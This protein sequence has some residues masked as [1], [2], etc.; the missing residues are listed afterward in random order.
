MSLARI[1]GRIS[2]L[3]PKQKIVAL[4]QLNA[5]IAT[6]RWT[7][8]KTM[9]TMPHEY[10]VRKHW[11][12]QTGLSFDDAVAIVRT[13]GYAA[14]WGRR[15]FT[16]L[17]VNGWKYWTMG[18]PIAETTI[19]N[20]A[21]VEPEAALYDAIAG[22]YDSLFD[23]AQSQT[24][25]ASVIK[26]AEPQGRVLDIGCGTGALLAHFPATFDKT[27]YTGIDISAGMVHIAQQ[28]Y[29]TL[30]S[31][32]HVVPFHDWWDRGYDTVLALFG[33]ASYLQPEDIERIPYLLTPTGRAILMFYDA[34]YRPQTHQH[35]HATHGIAAPQYVSSTTGQL[36][37]DKY[38]VVVMTHKSLPAL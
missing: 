25:N 17:H 9:P 13:Y 28:Q 18:S 35:A 5:A 32:F 10:A 11:N 22:Q 29:Q 14:S 23:D 6:Q 4:H 3:T 1:V 34:A 7:F 27:Q 33:V 30:A 38:R 16:Y 26:L 2:T 15:V 20:R 37:F 19:L 24:E 8:A 21:R 12:T 31:Q 36:L